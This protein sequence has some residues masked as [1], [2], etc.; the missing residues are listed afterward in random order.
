[1][2]LAGRNLFTVYRSAQNTEQLLLSYMMAYHAI[3]IG[4]DTARDVYNCIG[5]AYRYLL[6]SVTTFNSNHCRNNA[7][8]TVPKERT[9]L[10]LPKETQK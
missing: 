4:T 6:Q 8:K 2:L 1:M 3:K 9:P 7:I 10:K 5:T